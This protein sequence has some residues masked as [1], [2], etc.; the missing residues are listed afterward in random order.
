MTSSNILGQ[1]EELALSVLEE[2]RLSL[3][4]SFRF[5]DVALWTMPLESRSMVASLG[6]DGRRLYYDPV[7]VIWLYQQDPNEVLRGYLHAVMHCVYHHPFDNK[8]PRKRLWDLSC[9]IAVEATVLDLCGLMYPTGRDAELREELEKLNACV[10]QLTARKLYRFLDASQETSNEYTGAVY[11]RLCNLFARD[12]HAVWSRGRAGKGNLGVLDEAEVFNDGSNIKV[13]GNEDDVEMEDQPNDDAS[14]NSEG[15]AA[16]SK[17]GI[18]YEAE[19]EN[20]DTFSL[21]DG[22]DTYEELFGAIED[23][24]LTNP[25]EVKWKDISK[26]MEMDV[27]LFLGKAGF[28]PG[29][30]LVN[31]SVANRKEYDYRD[32]LKRFSS[33]SEEMKIS[34]DEFD[35]IYY[36]FGL[37]K[38]KNMPLIEPLEYQESDRVRDF[39]IAIDTS[40]SCAGELVKVF[41]EKTYD[42]L[43]SSEGFGRKLNVH[44]IQCDCDLRK[45]VKIT[46]VRELDKGFDEFQ[47]RGYGGTDFRPVFKYVDELIEKREL[48]HLK[49]LIYLTDGLGKFPTTPPDYDTVFVFVNE[50]SAE[51]GAPHIP[52]WAMK[53]V[54]DEDD[55][56]EL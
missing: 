40:A 49:G 13:V 29:T 20:G 50:L 15:A 30:F 5:M 11:D 31:M 8:H 19:V 24:K 46:S 1:A 14:T 21:G 54:M 27:K 38:Y 35:Y 2:A 51:K 44:I 47:L 22:A 17:G 37:R 42:V 4:A 23:A 52:P 45:D 18:Q 7:R 36:T 39:V 26:Q 6:S 9:D 34:P 53:V 10:P 25:D 28:D 43:K 56:L 12:D 33:R 55:I 48:N 32:F 3:A 16:D 41:V